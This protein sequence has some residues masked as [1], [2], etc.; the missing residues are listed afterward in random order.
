MNNFSIRNLPIDS[1]NFEVLRKQNKIYIDK[2]DLIFEFAQDDAPIFLSR[3]R[4]FGKSLLTTT[5]K[6]L[7]EHGL[8]YFEGLKISKLWNDTT[9]PVLYLNFS[10]YKENDYDFFYKSLTEDIKDFIEKYELISD[11]K[12]KNIYDPIELYRKVIKNYDKEIVILIDEYDCQL[13]HSMNKP[14]LY[15][16]FRSLIS[17]FFLTIKANRNKIRF[18]FITGVT[19]HSNTNIFSGLNN[20]TDISSSSQYGT[21]VGFTQDEINQYFSTF[22]ENAA[23]NL[24][25]SID[26]IKNELKDN[27]NG[28]CFSTKLDSHVYNP[29][30]VIRFFS[31]SADGFISYWIDSGFSSFVVKYFT[32]KSK[33]KNNLD[34][35]RILNAPIKLS[36]NDIKSNVPIIEA[37]P[38]S[39]LYQSGFL[40]LNQKDVFG[41]KATVPNFEVRKALSSQFFDM[42]NDSKEVFVDNLDGSFKALIQEGLSTLNIKKILEGFQC[43]L[44]NFR[45]GTNIFAKEIHICD[46]ISGFIHFLD[47]IV[48]REDPML[49]GDSDLIIY[50]KNTR[51]L[52]EFKIAKDESEAHKKLNEAINQILEKEYGKNSETTK[53]YRFGV[54]FNLEK[55]V[56]SLG[57][58][59]EE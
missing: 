50:Y 4:R 59:I 5:I 20:L 18:L 35:F 16:Q 28:F 1:T 34:I 29:W 54:V 15:E 13:T 21:L 8:E 27:Y 41:F 47:A 37:K 51:Y 26:N 30:S 9:Y 43:I 19:R 32:S 40:T 23:K 56:F 48:K 45:P 42:I 38:E 49:L 11:I 22:I 52:F 55:R 2:T 39:I 25:T 36:E 10:N 12:Y 53:L 17:S 14:E 44:N 57:K 46:A 7:F 6:S 3:P 24:N 31:A 58:L 33:E